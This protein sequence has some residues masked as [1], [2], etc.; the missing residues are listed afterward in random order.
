[1]LSVPKYTNPIYFQVLWNRKYTFKFWPLITR[2][3]KQWLWRTHLKS[4]PA[5]LKV[6]FE[7]EVVIH[8]YIIVDKNLSI[9]L[10]KL[11]DGWCNAAAR[12]TSLFVADLVLCISIRRSSK[13]STRKAIKASVVLVADIFD[14]S[15][16]IFLSMQTTQLVSFDKKLREQETIISDGT[17]MLL[18]ALEVLIGYIKSHSQSILPVEYTLYSWIIIVDRLFLV[19]PDVHKVQTKSKLK[20]KTFRIQTAD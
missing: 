20:L 1:M 6:S 11:I 10:N 13:A 8:W 19:K 7:C 12:T 18:Y 15:K 4:V 14:I 16:C 3:T 5:H 2:Q 9:W 17:S